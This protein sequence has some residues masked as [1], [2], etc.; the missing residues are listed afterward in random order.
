M[1][2]IVLHERVSVYLPG[3]IL[4]ELNPLSNIEIFMGPKEDSFP[5]R[6]WLFL[7]GAIGFEVAGTTAM[8]ISDGLSRLV[9]SV[10]LFICYAI[11]FALL[12]FALK[13][14]DVSLAY[15]VWSGVGTAVI[16]AIGIFYFQ[17]PATALKLISLSL[18]IAGVVGLNLD[19]GH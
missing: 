18:I 16:S 5:M 19:G 8:K 4:A 6:E 17:E 13:R 3:Q 14:I 11:S 12:S 10:L 9:P 2:M 1:L 15:A 7:A